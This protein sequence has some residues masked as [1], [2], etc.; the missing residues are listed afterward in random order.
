MPQNPAEQFAEER[1][2]RGQGRGGEATDVVALSL[3]KQLEQDE[4]GHVKAKAQ[5]SEDQVLA[6]QMESAV[7]AF[8]AGEG[9][10][11]ESED[12]QHEAERIEREA[13][14]LVAGIDGQLSAEAVPFVP[15]G[16]FDAFSPL[17]NIAEEEEMKIPCAYLQATLED[18]GL[19]KTILRI[20]AEEDVVKFTDYLRVRTLPA[21][22]LQSEELLDLFYQELRSTLASC[23]LDRICPTL[24]EVEHRFKTHLPPG[25]PHE[26]DVALVLPMLARKVPDTYHILPADGRGRPIMVFFSEA[27]SGFKGFLD[28]DCTLQGDGDFSQES[29][30]QLDKALTDSFRISCDFRHAAFDVRSKVQHFK[31]WPLAEVE[32]L[33]HAAVGKKK[34]APWEDHL[35]P[36]EHVHS[37]VLERNTKQW[38]GTLGHK[39]KE[40]WT[41]PH[42]GQN[43]Y[44]KFQRDW[45][46]YQHYVADKESLQMAQPG[47]PDR[48]QH[49]P[50]LGPA[51]PQAQR[52]RRQLNLSQQLYG[53]GAKNRAESVR[54][55]RSS[56]SEAK[57]QL[58]G[59]VPPVEIPEDARLQVETL[60]S[61]CPDG[62]RFTTLKRVLH[63]FE[64]AGGPSYGIVDQVLNPSFPMG[65]EEPPPGLEK[66]PPGLEEPPPGLALPQDVNAL[67]FQ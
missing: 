13:L 21:S 22:L 32:L 33:L 51:R 67:A 29:W 19:A 10:E 56:S 57:Y 41:H 61:A 54:S 64:E 11:D 7:A 45:E 62:L 39:K 1:R 49:W 37:L 30:E 6:G 28:V 3:L 17:E 58:S 60:V 36:A 4:E 65:L 16:S 55:N 35:G 12:E 53:D 31:D 50:S 14:D 20:P 2:R 5:P 38:E 59:P 46:A 23:Y 8:L 40:S 42:R 25:S 52:E 34:L 15:I 66:P 18:V 44:S 48:D 47:H 9:F 63:A 27:P 26:L 43:G 24:Q